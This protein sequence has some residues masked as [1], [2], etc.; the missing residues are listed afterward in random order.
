MINIV[1]VDDDVLALA[2]LKQFINLDSV[3]IVG[4]FTQAEQALEFMLKT[5]VDILITDMRMPKLDG[6]ELI[7]EIR[8]ANPKLQVIAVSSYEDFNY[9]KESFREGSIDYILKHVLSEVSLTKAITEAISKIDEGNDEDLDQL[10]DESVAQES[11]QA[12]KIKLLTQLLKNEISVEDAQSKFEKF[13]IRLNISSTLLVVC[14]IDDY[15]TIT[16]D[17]SPEDR[18]IFLSSIV[19]LM[20]RVLAKVPEKEIIR[21]SDSKYV[22]FFSYPHVR[23]QLYMYSTTLDYCKRLNYN[24]E[25]MLNI[26]LSVGIGECCSNLRDFIS[27]YQKCEQML[28]NK[29]FEGKGQF[30]DTQKLKD[31][32]FSMGNVSSRSQIDLEGIFDCLNKGEPAILERIES[33]FE[34]FTLKKYPIHMIELQMIDLLN[35]GFKVIKNHQLVSLQENQKFNLLYQKV[36]NVETIGEMKNII[37]HFYE[38]IISNIQDL[39]QMHSQHYNKFTIRAME[40]IKRN[41]MQNISLQDIADELDVNSTYLSKIFKADTGYN[42]SEYLNRFRIDQAKHLIATNKFKIKEI[43]GQVGFNQYNYFFKVFRQVTGLTPAEYEKQI[44]K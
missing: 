36:K 25:N 40:S 39:N 2:N 21:M 26:K 9:V 28:Q 5:K 33:I 27:S 12:L 30:Y 42:Y 31:N 16:S 10:F 29:F 44:T 32:P 6:I 11:L 4:E 8:T 17:F 37:V 13:G 41:Y 14:E 19:D 1:L 23:S 34:Q 38:A 22:L 3:H 35:Q 20:E 18:R 7:R 15:R 24:L 43:Y